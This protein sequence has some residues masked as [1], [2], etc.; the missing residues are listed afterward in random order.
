MEFSG[1]F[2]KTGEELYKQ[3]W[4]RYNASKR[5]E[6]TSLYER[7]FGKPSSW[8]V[9]RRK[10]ATQDMITSSNAVKK[11]RHDYSNQNKRWYGF[12]EEA[13]EILKRH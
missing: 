11:L 8:D 4:K 9:W 12:H 2:N 10:K 6:K 7:F 13:Q 5:Y 3:D 1:S